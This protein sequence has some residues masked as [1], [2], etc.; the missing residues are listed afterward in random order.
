VLALSHPLMRG[1][2]ADSQ[3][4]D[5]QRLEPQEVAAIFLHGITAEQR[6]AEQITLA[7]ITPEHLAP[8]HITADRVGAGRTT[9][10][11]EGT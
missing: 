5:D 4:E 2:R 6:S 1:P 8:E 11:R 7:Q 10:D 3:C 9:A